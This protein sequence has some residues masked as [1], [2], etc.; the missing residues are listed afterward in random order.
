MRRRRSSS[1]AAFLS[2]PPHNF[3]D[4]TGIGCVVMVA[5]VVAQLEKSW[6]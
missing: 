6:H 1:F 3:S 4:S 2:I 5:I